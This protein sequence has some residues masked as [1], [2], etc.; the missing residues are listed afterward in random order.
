MRERK[1]KKNLRHELRHSPEG[2]PAKEREEERGEEK[3]KEREVNKVCSFL[4]F[5]RQT[6]RRTGCGLTDYLTAG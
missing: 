1:E 2:R 4:Y 3:N 5:K 6:S